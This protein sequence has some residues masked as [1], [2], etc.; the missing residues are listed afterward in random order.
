M[1]HL[2][3]Q[4]T[5]NHSWWI[6]YFQIVSKH[7]SLFSQASFPGFIICSLSL[8]PFF[9]L[10]QF[11]LLIFFTEYILIMFPFPQ[12]L[13]DLLHLPTY[14]TACFVCL[15]ET[16]NIKNKNIKMKTKTRQKCQNKMKQKTHQ[17][18]PNHGVRFVVVFVSQLLHFLQ[19]R[20][21]L[22]FYL[23]NIW[24]IIWCAHDR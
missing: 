11:S 14:L 12:F 17:N 21:T 3:F 9:F 22:F 16:T 23:N 13:P 19:M 2:V 6:H 20:H 5:E 1:F 24:L 18:K 7:N 10:L 4:K 15:S 8:H